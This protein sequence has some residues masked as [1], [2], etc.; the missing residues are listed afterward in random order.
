[1]K[2]TYSEILR[3]L[4]ILNT[5]TKATPSHPLNTWVLSLYFAQGLPFFL[6][7]MMSSVIYKSLG[8]NNTC[9]IIV[10][11]CFFIP[12]TMKP[13]LSVFI[14]RF[15]S[16]RHWTITMELSIGITLLITAMTLSLTHFFLYSLTLFI[17][18]SFMA[19][20]H[21]I[22]SDGYYL[23]ALNTEDRHRH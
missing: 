3:R 14:E 17:L 15:S 4:A 1:M 16:V 6:I 18:L 19:A 12:W 23:M 8:I 11:S 20:S 7:T 5:A 13:A 9:I 22:C 21:D 10:S 2:S